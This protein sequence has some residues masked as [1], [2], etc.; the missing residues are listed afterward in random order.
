MPTFEH[1]AL[2]QPIS[3]CLYFHYQEPQS[4]NAI[5]LSRDDCRYDIP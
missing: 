2:K 4:K 3:T 1:M 5:I